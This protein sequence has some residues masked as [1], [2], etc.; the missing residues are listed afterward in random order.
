[1]RNGDPEVNV[2]IDGGAQKR[3]KPWQSD[4]KRTDKSKHQTCPKRDSYFGEA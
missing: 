2:W 1:M 4:S 3:L